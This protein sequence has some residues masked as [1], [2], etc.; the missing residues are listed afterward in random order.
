M[1]LV[2]LV[3]RNMPWHGYGGSAEVP[4]KV[5][6]PGVRPDRQLRRASP[7]MREI[8]TACWDANPVVRPTFTQ[9]VAKLQRAVNAQTSGEAEGDGG[10]PRLLVAADAPAIT[11]P[12]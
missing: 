7:L 4:Y 6:K 12:T 1:C 8:I 3:D 9:V 2:E 11:G 5:T 10:A